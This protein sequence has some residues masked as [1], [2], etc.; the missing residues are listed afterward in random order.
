[1]AGCTLNARS[2]QRLEGVHPDLVAVVLRAAELTETPFQVVEGL[3][4]LE[5]QRQYVRQG[6][7]RTLKSRHLT[8][9]AVDVAPWIGPD[10]DWDNEGGY[11]QIW[12]AFK[13]ASTELRIPLEWGGNW[14]GFCDMPHMQLPWLQYPTGSNSKP[15]N[16]RDLIAAGSRTVRAARTVRR[17]G[18]ATTVVAVTAAALANSDP[19][20]TAT[21]AVGTASSAVSVAETAVT[22]V[23]RSKDVVGAAREQATWLLTPATFV[24][25]A[26]VLGVALIGLGAMIARYRIQ[27]DNEGKNVGRP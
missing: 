4:T 7:S 25:F 18:Q 3:R 1:M 2:T 24:V 27:D 16:E 11:R 14:R 23:A 22:V 8:G 20:T 19:I 5:R 12:A 26:I 13:A 10:F 21:V 6:A 15:R 17:I 9:H